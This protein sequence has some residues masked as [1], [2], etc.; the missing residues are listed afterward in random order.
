MVWLAAQRH[1]RARVSREERRASERGPAVL[2][3]FRRFLSGW[4]SFSALLWLAR[5]PSVA[6][7]AI[8]GG[9]VIASGFV[10]SGRRV[11]SAM[12]ASAIL[13]LAQMIARFPRTANHELLGLAAVIVTA[14]IDERIES[15]RRLG[16]AALRAMVPIVFV[17]SGIQKL[18]SGCWFQGEFLLIGALQSDRFRALQ[19]IVPRME[20][21]ALRALS[22][23]S[24]G[25][26]PY[27]FESAP[28]LLLSNAVW[29]LE[30]I[31][32]LLLLVPRL[33]RFAAISL[34]LL[35]LG[36]ELF[37]RELAFGLLSGGLIAL[38]IERRS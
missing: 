3:L 17:W 34:L 11:R 14:L 31:L 2:A 20:M 25:S 32:P 10:L 13:I 29:M 30:L 38:W 21:N 9:L 28:P 33:R 8:A 23:S 27:H 7:G 37:A 36:I 24:A 35:L 19:L 22:P 6:S 15:E 12:A 5:E 16:I 4:A 18:L 26:G 1:T